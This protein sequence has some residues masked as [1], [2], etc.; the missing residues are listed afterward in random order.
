MNNGIKRLTNSYSAG[1]GGARFESCVQAMYLT[2]M[3]TQGP[4]PCLPPWPIK[5]IRLQTRND[6]AEL[7]DMMVTVQNPNGSEQCKLFAQIRHFVRITERDD[8]FGGIIRAAW[9][10]FNN[11]TLFERNADRLALI[12]GP[13]SSI[14]DTKWLLSQARHTENV[15]EFS[16]K[17]G[18]AYFSSETK[19]KKLEV[20]KNQ[21]KMANGDVEL[22]DDT[23]YLFLRHFH[24]AGYDLGGE[25]SDTF[26]LLLSHISQFN[27]NPMFLW[28]R[29]VDEVQKWN[30]DAGTITHQNLPDDL[31]EAVVP[32]ERRSSPFKS[33]VPQTPSTDELW[34][35]PP[36][37]SELVFASLLGAWN[38]NNVADR[39]L[40]QQLTHKEFDVWLQSVRETLQLPSSPIALR[41][42]QWH[43]PDRKALWQTI[44]GRVFDYNLDDLEEVAVTVLSERDPKLKLPARERH[45]AQVYGAVPSHSYEL[46]KGMA[47]SLALLGNQHSELKFCSQHK[48][49]IVASLS[50]RKIF[51][52]ADWE[53][54]GSLDSLLPTLA[55]ASPDEFLEAV[56]SGLQLQPC[57][58]DELFLQGQT[59]VFGES[60]IVG[61]LWALET[62][63]WDKDYL[64][65][66]CIVLGK[67]ASR[68]PGGNSTSRPA[69]SLTRILLPWLPQTTASLQKRRLAVEALQMEDPETAWKLL[70]SLL[71]SERGFSHPTH[72]P[73]WRDSG[74]ADWTESVSQED[75]MEQVDLY[76]NMSVDMAC[77]DMDK[78]GDKDFIDR[79]HQLPQNARDRVL[80]HISSDAISSESEDKLLVLWTELSRFVRVQREF[81][82]ASWVLGVDEVA[83]IEK[84]A[85]RLSPDNPLVVHRMLFSDNDISLYEDWK[86]GG[87]LDDQR[88]LRRQQ[89]LEDILASGGVDAVIQFAQRVENPQFVGN[90][91]AVLADAETDNR[92][93]PELLETDDEKHNLFGQGYVW[94]RRYK[95]GWEWADKLDRSS[96]T[97]AQVGQFLSWL[98]FTEEAWKKAEAWLG[99]QEGE[100]W[101]RT[102]AGLRFGTDG[103]I[104]L[105]IDKL[106]KYRRPKA[107]I[108]CLALMKHDSGTFDKQQAIR[109]LLSSGDPDEPV[110]QELRYAIIEII[111]ELQSDPEANQEDLMKV[112]WLYLP[113]LERHLGALPKTLE[114]GLAS[115]PDFYC[116]VIQLI[117]LPEGQDGRSKQLS[118]QE[119]AFAQCAYSL[120]FEWKTPPGMQPDGTF[121]PEAFTKWLNHV[122]AVCGE[123]GHLGIALEQVGEVLGA[124]SVSNPDGLC[125]H[126]TVEV[127]LNDRNVEAMRE[128][129]SIGISNSRG[130]YV[131]DGTGNEE[132]E[133]ARKYRQKA[134][135]IE[136]E[137]HH[138]LATTIRRLAEHYDREA[139]RNIARRDQLD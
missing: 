67:L 97:D 132:R 123:S 29:I 136:K 27:E 131:I 107:A 54:W 86:D 108:E 81:S 57:P 101:R 71:P 43:V 12:T 28:G 92:L 42:G 3:L 17:V 112:E 19:R 40:I 30:L 61:L 53:L 4:A 130:V 8:S 1:A 78:L 134:D 70:I 47:E 89:A 102:R 26:P 16:R 118:E 69:N 50:L 13:K 94:V 21:L 125:I 63:A 111:Q 14:E 109:A 106:V 52:N 126:P 34:N 98:P 55:E 48:P 91:L 74:L 75:Y 117:F 64:I 128:G 77:Q 31:V 84:V 87:D 6:G 38:E 49:E 59:S 100:Y 116:Q 121:S 25:L 129:F 124:H 95:N 83:K 39:G 79:L 62:L 66:V 46:R 22:A 127:E 20:I 68:D 114:F 24:L 122:K 9:G 82:S 137:G 105:A 15:E 11:G 7:D 10:D 139:E 45:A 2:L 56:E 119:K 5:E 41:N 35:Q 18:L 33:P 115:D 103:D 44:G 138:R 51:E 85:G 90:V 80:E 104:G 32:L 65:R 113:L 58:F 93:F 135:A 120:L 96:W 110:R 36:L 133:L 76:A 73:S 60:Y 88:N 99:K 72:R 37:A 23:T